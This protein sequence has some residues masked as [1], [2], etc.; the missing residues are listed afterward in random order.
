MA[1]ARQG[2]SGKEAKRANARWYSPF[3]FVLH[4][5]A[6]VGPVL[7][8][9]GFAH[10]VEVED[11]AYQT[12]AF[13]VPAPESSYVSW[14]TEVNEFGT[15]VAQA[16]GV[17]ASTA[18][19]FAGWILEA[20]T[21][22][23]LEPELLASL[24]LTESSF[25]KNVRSHVGAIGPAQVRPEFWSNF[26][27]ISNLHDPA[28]NIYCGAQVLSY[29]RDRCGDEGCA[30]HAYNVGLYAPR[31]QAGHRYVAKID[32]YREQLLKLPL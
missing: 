3:L 9:A 28:E 22:Q 15:K 5:L 23:E 20:S 6:I 12:Y 17:R 26:C 29:L 19:E 8:A 25:R 13:A 10:R 7:L 2:K 30:L 14:N 4:S 11:V 21:R 24:V 18:T 31:H 32:H 1:T 27:G 16:F